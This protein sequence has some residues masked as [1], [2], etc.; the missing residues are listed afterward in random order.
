MNLGY[1]DGAIYFKCHS[2]S[3]KAVFSL[4]FGIKNVSADRV[5]VSKEFQTTD[6]AV[7]PAVECA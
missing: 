3:D 4:D 7:E 5:I 6:A 1:S 2:I